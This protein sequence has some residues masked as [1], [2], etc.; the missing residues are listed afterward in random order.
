MGKE[1]LDQFSQ[2][3]QKL[4]P[5]S[6]YSCVSFR[7]SNGNFTVRASIATSKI[8][9]KFTWNINKLHCKVMIRMFTANNRNYQ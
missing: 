2:V 3:V 4:T 7:D 9:A 5:C 1:H 6:Q 8:K